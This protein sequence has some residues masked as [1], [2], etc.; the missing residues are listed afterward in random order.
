[1]CGNTA[2]ET[3]LLGAAGKETA[4]AASLR[5]DAIAQSAAPRPTSHHIVES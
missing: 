5:I 4:M 2:G 3:A 1:V